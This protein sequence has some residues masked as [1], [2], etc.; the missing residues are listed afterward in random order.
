MCL[1][2]QLCEFGLCVNLS[3]YT[4]LPLLSLVKI[5]VHYVQH[6]LYMSWMLFWRGKGVISLHQ[7]AYVSAQKYLY[8][9][10]KYTLLCVF[11]Q[12]PGLFTISDLG[13][14]SRKVARRYRSWH[15]NTSLMPR[16]YLRATSSSSWNI[17]DVLSVC[18]SAC[19]CVCVTH[20]RGGALE[21]GGVHP[22]PG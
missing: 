6:L 18:L 9:L 20:G 2:W 11:I 14:I 15:R 13:G 17:W 21:K 22:A 5:G 12:H 8:V 3:D 19:L 7:K 16:L 4:A 10:F 1:T